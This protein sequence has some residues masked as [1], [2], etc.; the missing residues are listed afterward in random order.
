VI[1]STERIST[2]KRG[3]EALAFDRSFFKLAKNACSKFLFCSNVS[4]LLF[5]IVAWT[6]VYGKNGPNQARDSE[7]ARLTNRFSNYTDH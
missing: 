6:V 2:L 7:H 1:E 4:T 3:R 5:I